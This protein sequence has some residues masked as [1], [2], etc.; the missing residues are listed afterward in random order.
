MPSWAGI[1]PEE[2]KRA[3][4][5]LQQE[6][7]AALSSLER[8]WQTKMLQREKEVMENTPGMFFYSFTYVKM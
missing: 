4:G 2:A 1:A 6:Q 8:A 7:E 3:L 5:R